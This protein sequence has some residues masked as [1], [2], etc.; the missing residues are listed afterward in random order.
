MCRAKALHLI[1]RPIRHLVTPCTNPGINIVNGNRLGGGR[2]PAGGPDRQ[3]QGVGQG[4]HIHTVIDT[5]RLKRDA[6]KVSHA[7]TKHSS[8]FSLFQNKHAPPLQQLHC[9]SP[10]FVTTDFSMDHPEDEEDDDEPKDEKLRL[11]SSLWASV[12]F[13]VRPRLDFVLERGNLIEVPCSS[14]P[15]PTPSTNR[16]CTHTHARTSTH[17]HTHTHL[18]KH[19]VNPVANQ[20]EETDPAEKLW[21]F[22]GGDE[23]NY[24][25][26]RVRVFACV[27]EFGNVCIIQRRSMRSIGTCTVHACVRSIDLCVRVCTYMHAT[28]PSFLCCVCLCTHCIVDRTNQSTSQPTDTHD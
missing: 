19:Q 17:T 25:K 23:E 6:Q 26:V 13:M 9:L 24:S 11:C 21:V 20:P 4:T 27:W 28:R 7:E 1:E 5:N 16:S 2:H 18:H 3:H 10:S 15:S 14:L 22:A 8:R 12:G